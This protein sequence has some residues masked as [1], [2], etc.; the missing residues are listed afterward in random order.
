MLSTA[1]PDSADGGESSFDSRRI[2][3]AEAGRPVVVRKFLS[4][5]NCLCFAVFGGVPVGIC[6]WSSRHKRCK[7]KF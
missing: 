5:V 3:P 6:D 2:I 1:T 7:I 4:W